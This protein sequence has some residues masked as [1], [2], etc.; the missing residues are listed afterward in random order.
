MTTQLRP[1]FGE[2]G[3]THFLQGAI[4]VANL[5]QSTA[6]K[7]AQ[8]LTW[9]EQPFLQ[10]EHEAFLGRFSLYSGNTGIL[11]FLFQLAEATNNDQ[12]LKDAADGANFIV[13]TWDNG[14]YVQPYGAI[15]NSH[16]CMVNGLAGISYVISLIA[17]KTKN[18]ELHNFS[19]SLV[20][21]IAATAII[22]NETVHWTDDPGVVFDSGLILFLLKMEK[23]YDRP[24]WRTLAI[25]AGN[26]ILNKAIRVDENK[27]RWP[28]VSPENFGLPVDSII[29]NFF[30]GTSGVAFTLATLYE[31]TGNKEYLE[32]SI[33]G[34][35]YIQSIATIKENK[36]LIPHSLPYLKDIHYL[37]LC[38]GATGTIRL[39]FK[40]YK[41]TKDD[42]YKQ[43]IENIVNG[44]L[45]T[46]APELHS[47]GYWNTTC[48]CCGSAGLSNMF[49]GLWAEFKE[50]KYLKN[51]LRV[52]KHLLSESVFD[53]EKGA[54]WYQAWDRKSPEILTVKTGY[55]DGAA[56]NGL[57][58]LH[59]YL[60]TT[61]YFNVVRLPEDPYPTQ[62]V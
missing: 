3:A 2:P 59:I 38:H 28:H 61:D 19:I 62:S 34:A 1:L 14:K 29:P 41:I 16:L 51:A 31:E 23:I 50:E 55:Y 21:E 57:E 33:L 17:S 5:L 9:P 56:G 47:A 13:N 44:V 54:Y 7:T 60:A 39:F 4:E 15:T 10:Q 40:L 26:H 11:F 35:N 32:A 30:Y 12:Y 48:Q 24:E 20:Q 25:K 42:T 22:N 37:G 8:G 58:L 45:A 36:I 43:W 52:G 27:L 49:L 46:G 53:Q 18:L 6:I